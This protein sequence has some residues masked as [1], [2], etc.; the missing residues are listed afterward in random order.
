MYVMKAQDYSEALLYHLQWK[1]QLRKF[2]DGQGHFNIADLSPENC[3]LGKW[4]HSDKI[5]EYSS[6]AE[7]RE[8]E[9]V[10]TKFHEQAKRV[11]GLKKL[12]EDFDARQKL[13]KLEAT[14][15]KLVSLLTT[16]KATSQS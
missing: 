16:L 12:G 2:L 1:V 4:L 8:I 11:Y 5:T 10:H 13:C 15:T 9:K 7:I 6:H 14:S 3:K